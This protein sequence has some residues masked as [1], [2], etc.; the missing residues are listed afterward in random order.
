MYGDEEKTSLGLTA[1]E[2]VIRSRS[3]PAVARSDGNMLL[4]TTV[5]VLSPWEMVNCLIQLDIYL[6]KVLRSV[7]D[8]GQVCKYFTHCDSNIQTRSIPRSDRTCWQAVRVHPFILPLIAHLYLKC[9][10][11]TGRR[12]GILLKHKDF[13]MSWLLWRVFSKCELDQF[14]YCSYSQQ[15][16]QSSRKDACS[17]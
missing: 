6:N 3:P 17:S 4:R 10:Q 14:I 7:F 11:I 5:A 12:T 16:Y 8:E 2:R 1:D 9:G 15:L 13:L